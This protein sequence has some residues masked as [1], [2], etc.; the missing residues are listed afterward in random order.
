ML[1]NKHILHGIECKRIKTF[2]RNGLINM[3]IRELR[4]NVG[5]DLQIYITF[6]IYEEKSERHLKPNQL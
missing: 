6:S 1:I 4:K 3:Q 2:K 5:I